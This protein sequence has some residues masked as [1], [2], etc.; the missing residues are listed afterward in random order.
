MKKSQFARQSFAASVLSLAIAAASAQSVPTS[1]AEGGNRWFIELVGAPEADGNTRAAVKA[2]KAAFRQ[3]A[4]A[5]GVSYN[6]RRAFDVLFNGFSV[7]ATA[8]ERA[9][10]ASLPGFKAMYPVER[11][12][13][14]Q[15]EP[16]ATGAAPDLAAAIAHDRRQPRRRPPAGPAP[17]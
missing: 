3:A 9:K 6:E 13:A 16:G 1:S 2:E 12:Q 15:P 11:I 7:E 17:A 8:A 4:A 14:P 10:L 5:L